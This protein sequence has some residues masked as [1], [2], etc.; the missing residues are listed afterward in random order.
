MAVRKAPP[1]VR[2]TATERAEKARVKEVSARAVREALYAGLRDGL[3]ETAE[4]ILAESQKATPVGA[5]TGLKD[6]GHLFPRRP[7]VAG[8]VAWVQVRYSAPYAMFVHEGT[9]PHFPP[10]EALLR[11]CELVLGIKDEKE[12]RRAAWAIARTIAKYGTKPHTFLRDAAEKVLPSMEAILGRNLKAAFERLGAPMG[13][14][15]RR[16]PGA[17]AAVRGA[18]ALATSEAVAAAME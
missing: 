17:A 16:D 8:N 12:A 7:H 10:P 13:P 1:R 18:S 6:S 3:E 4:A 11:W 15:V 14:E 5:T 9:R 2:P